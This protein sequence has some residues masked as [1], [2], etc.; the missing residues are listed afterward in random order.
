MYFSKSDTCA[1]KPA[2]AG[3]VYANWQALSM[4]AIAY[5]IRGIC[6]LQIACLFRFAAALLVSRRG[7]LLA[8]D[9]AGEAYQALT[10]IGHDISDGTAIN[11]M[12]STAAS[13]H[14][15]DLLDHESVRHAICIPHCLPATQLPGGFAPLPS[16]MHVAALYTAGCP[17]PDTCRWLARGAGLQDVRGC[18]RRCRCCYRHCCR[19]FGGQREPDPQLAFTA[20]WA[21][22]CTWWQQP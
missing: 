1:A 19:T 12:L 15:L 14:H 3:S 20:E 6:M 16:E 22:W 5:W 21:E 7:T 9:E 4:C 10:N 13:L 8:T 17:A 11:G 2:P 18:S